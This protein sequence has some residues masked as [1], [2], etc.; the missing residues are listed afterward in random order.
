MTSFDVAG[1][2]NRTCSCQLADFTDEPGSS[3][4]SSSASDTPQWLDII[5]DLSRKHRFENIVYTADSAGE[6][7]VMS[8][9]EPSSRDG[10]IPGEIFRRNQ[11]V[12]N[13]T[14]ESD[15]EEVVEISRVEPPRT[16]AQ[17]LVNSRNMLRNYLK[18]IN[19]W[20]KLPN[21][22]YHGKKIDQEMVRVCLK[23]AKIEDYCLII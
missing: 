22:A 3:S 12:A 1:R 6:E 15:E 19:Q 17:D 13:S 14:L 16:T 10:E 11:R 20:H 4:S 5:N 9:K 23:T 18:S 2:F 8:P 7:A 21:F